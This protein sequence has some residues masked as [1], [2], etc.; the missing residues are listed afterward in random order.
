MEDASRCFSID[1]LGYCTA[2]YA[3]LIGGTDIWESSAIIHGNCSFD[4]G[5]TRKIDTKNYTPKH[6]TPNYK[7]KFRRPMID[8]IIRAYDDER[9]P[10]ESSRQPSSDA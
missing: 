4:E 6:V 10:V 5:V 3:A 7:C 2:E 1:N 8:Q 9:F